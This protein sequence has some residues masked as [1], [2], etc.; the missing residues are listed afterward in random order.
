MPIH[1]V[2]RE[3]RLALGMTQEQMAAC[4][5]VSAPAVNKWEKGGT[6][7][8]IGLLAPLARLLRIDVNTLLCFQEDLTEQELTQFLKDM[9]ETM[10]RE[11]FAAVYALAMEK[12]REYPAC[13]QLTQNTAL[14]LEGALLTCGVTGEEQSQ[15]Q[16]EIE[17]LYL[18]LADS[19]NPKIRD[20]AA[21]CS[22]V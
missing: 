8:D 3:R 5:G 15:Y 9:A 12:L 19:E 17:A 16:Q 22:S 14:F 18:R 4:L 1:T 6:C 11:G 20:S 10:G 13:E 2:I 21:I 7:P